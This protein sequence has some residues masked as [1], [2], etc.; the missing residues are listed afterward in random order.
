MKNK[1][2]KLLLSFAVVGV[3]IIGIIL[4]MNTE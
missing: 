1:D 3:V 4:Y 2:G